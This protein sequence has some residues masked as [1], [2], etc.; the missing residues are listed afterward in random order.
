MTPLTKASCLRVYI[1]ENAHIGP[2]PIYEAILI[3]LKKNGLS[4]A[5]VFRGV[6]AYGHQCTMQGKSLHGNW[7][8]DDLPILVETIGAAEKIRAVVPE[9]ISMMKNR[10]LVTCAELDVLHQGINFNVPP[11]DDISK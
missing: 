7:L 4:G 8:K 9:I 2:L 1:D 5:T 10:G 3:H 11:A 6:L